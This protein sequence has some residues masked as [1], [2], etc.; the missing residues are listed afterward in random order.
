MG[1]F[2]HMYIYKYM[3]REC[4]CTHLHYVVDSFTLSFDAMH[5]WNKVRSILSV[6]TFIIFSKHIVQYTHS[7]TYTQQQKQ[8]QEPQ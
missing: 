2:S 6:W 1:S 4:T 5:I 3:Y 8:K 7:Q